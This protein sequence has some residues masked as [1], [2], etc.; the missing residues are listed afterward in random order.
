V[1]VLTIGLAASMALMAVG[2]A[3]AVGEGR[4]RSH[5]VALGEILPF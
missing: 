3:L 5:P 1:A 4:L 2:L